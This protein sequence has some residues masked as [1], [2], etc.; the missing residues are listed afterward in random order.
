MAGWLAET[1]I[2]EE[3]ERLK[4]LEESSRQLQG[5]H[6]LLLDFAF[7]LNKQ[8]LEAEVA[9]ESREGAFSRERPLYRRALA[10]FLGRPLDADANATLRVSFASV[11][12]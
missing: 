11:R 9:R 7:D 1:R 5:R 12:G 4:M 8:I 2:H 10:R 6:D 3:G